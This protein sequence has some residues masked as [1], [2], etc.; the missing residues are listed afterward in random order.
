LTGTVLFLIYINDLPNCSSLFS[1]LFADDTAL[2]A[3]HS[4]LQELFSFVNQEFHKLCTYFRNNMLSLHPD[5]TK[6]LLISPNN[7]PFDTNLKLYINNNNPGETSHERILELSSVS[8]T[9]KIP[10][11]KYLGVYFDSQLNFKYHI[12]QISKKLSYALYTLRSVKNLLPPHSLKTLYYSL[13]HCHL[14]YGIEIW[15]TAPAAS[16]KPL[17]TKQKMAI[18]ILA[19]K[20]YNAHT[21]P[22]FKILEILPLNDLINFFKLK[23]FHSYV[24][25]TIPTAFASTWITTLEQRHNDGQLNLLYNLR[26][27]DDYFIPFVRTIF[28]SR[29]PLYSLPDLWNNLPHVLK[30][31]P[32]KKHFSISLKKHYLS[33][34]N[35]NFTCTRL[36][37]HTCLTAGL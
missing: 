24:F 26:N 20:T 22:L 12:S 5:K 1:Q 27:N 15:S 21:E 23:F 9:D 34:L 10:A 33:K 11:L 7:I 32:S 37:C 17:I 28:L 14:V 3:S 30:D 36:I 18:R 29:F 2:S 25:N 35:E 31:I 8:P 16:I 4:N 19:N 13:F 6:F